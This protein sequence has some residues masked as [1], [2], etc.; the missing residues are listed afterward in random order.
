M[1]APDSM[2]EGPR[3][4]RGLRGPPSPGRGHGVGKA[5]GTRPRTGAK[6]PGEMRAR[7]GRGQSGW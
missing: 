4:Q 6:G 1:S 2:R 3:K 5:A 7:A